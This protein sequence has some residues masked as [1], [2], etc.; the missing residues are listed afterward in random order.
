MNSIR[1]SLLLV[2]VLLFA[3]ACEGPEGPEGPPGPTGSDGQDGLNGATGPAGPAGAAGT[4][5]NVIYSAWEDIL[6]GDWLSASFYTSYTTYSSS[7]SAP[8][9]TQSIKDT[10]TILVYAKWKTSGTV[11]PSEPVLLP[12]YYNYSASISEQLFAL[13]L[14]SSIQFRLQ[15]YGSTDF[16]KNQTTTVRYV[17]IPGTKSGGRVAAAPVDYTDYAAV[18]AYYNLPD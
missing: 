1:K 18:A 11:I 14:S 9:L 13:P 2:F 15:R 17:L 8:S 6:S 4:S 3:L 12:Y 5:A 10:G 7:I 16:I